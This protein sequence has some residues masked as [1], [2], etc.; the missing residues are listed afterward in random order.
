M[1]IERLKTWLETEENEVSRSLI[2]ELIQVY[3]D[4][5][6][7][8]AKSSRFVELIS[9]RNKTIE[10]L[11]K[12]IEDHNAE[13]DNMI[14]T[15]RKVAEDQEANTKSFAN[16][17]WLANYSR[18]PL[19]SSKTLLRLWR[20]VSNM[21]QSRTQQEV[22]DNQSLVVI[23]LGELESDQLLVDARNSILFYEKHNTEEDKPSFIEDPEVMEILNEGK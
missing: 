11:T 1:S 5:D 20:N 4:L 18:S 13:R 19:F 6:S 21:F 14:L 17:Y 22:E 7:E 10:S 3:G 12:I 23:D 8:R 2:E 9:K 16:M 15:V